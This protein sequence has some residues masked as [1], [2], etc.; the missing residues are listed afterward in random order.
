MYRLR[1]K[2]V[3]LLSNWE[4]IIHLDWGSSLYQVDISLL[5]NRSH[6]RNKLHCLRKILTLILNNEQPV[7][8]RKLLPKYMSW[9]PLQMITK[10][11]ISKLGSQLYRWISICRWFQVQSQSITIPKMLLFR[12]LTKAILVVHMTS[13]YPM[14]LLILDF[15][16]HHKNNLRFLT[17][18]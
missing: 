4:V 2:E 16:N 1:K 18:I 11:C 15:L 5:L 10:S 14:I 12:W 13:S 6:L 8:Q 3:S 17:T 7:Q 9:C